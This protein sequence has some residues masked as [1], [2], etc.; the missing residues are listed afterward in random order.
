MG[1]VLNTVLSVTLKQIL[2]QERP[3]SALRSGPGMPS[4][5][6]QSIFFTVVFTILSGKISFN[7]I[8]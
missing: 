2:N 5:H 6:A 7:S 1:S 4:S 8:L 3:V